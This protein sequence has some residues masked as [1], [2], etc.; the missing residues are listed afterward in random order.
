MQSKAKHYQNSRVQQELAV[1][2]Q[3]VILANALTST[4]AFGTSFA[5]NSATQVSASPT[6]SMLVRA[7]DALACDD[8]IVASLAPDLQYLI[9]NPKS[10]RWSCSL[11]GLNILEQAVIHQ[12]HSVISLADLDFNTPAN[13]TTEKENSQDAE[14]IQSIMN[15]RIANEILLKNEVKTDLSFLRQHSSNFKIADFRN[16]SASFDQISPIRRPYIIPPVFLEEANSA[17][18]FW[19]SVVFDHATISENTE[20][21]RKFFGTWNL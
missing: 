14:L 9:S 2:R 8:S 10:A 19:D 18:S 11:E 7:L 17:S 3:V 5:A 4:R 21:L 1:L 12:E 16:K 13:Y 15:S 6:R 20:I